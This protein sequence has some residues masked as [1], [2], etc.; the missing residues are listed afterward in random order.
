MG[1]N[2]VM[3]KIAS[4]DKVEL[5]NHKVEMA[6]VFED[7]S[8]ALTEMRNLN[9]KSADFKKAVDDK[10]MEVK[11]AQNAFK[12]HLDKIDFQIKLATASSD[13][14]AM[15]AQKLGLPV[16]DLA[17]TAPKVSKDFANIVKMDRK[18]YTV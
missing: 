5:A 10:K 1:L 13:R 11:K 6:T 4:A 17:K 7:V 12:D 16:P 18:N 14:L 2:E 3:K 8:G 15:E 9:I